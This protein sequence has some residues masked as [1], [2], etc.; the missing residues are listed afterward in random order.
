MSS[1][2][3]T[4][5]TTLAQ[6]SYRDGYRRFGDLGLP[7]DEYLSCLTAV[8]HKRLARLSHCSSAWV[9][10]RVSFLIRP[11]GICR[12]PLE[13]LA[14]IDQVIILW[15]FRMPSGQRSVVGGPAL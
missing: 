15:P 14:P 3:E 10:F 7:I 13:L 4:S 6:Q 12:Y 1:C 2:F 8:V 5:T 11:W 9:V